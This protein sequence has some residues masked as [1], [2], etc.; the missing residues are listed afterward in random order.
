MAIRRA[1]I[2]SDGTIH[3]GD[4][5]PANGNIHAK[6]NNPSDGNQPDIVRWIR[7]DASKTYYIRFADGD[8]PFDEA[9]FRVPESGDHTQKK[10]AAKAVVGRAYAYGV[11]SEGMTLADPDVIVD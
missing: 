7:D 2:S 9:E 8:S 6:K 3:G 11:S 1:H 10:V 5:D 4:T